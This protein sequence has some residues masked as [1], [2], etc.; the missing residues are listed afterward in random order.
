MQHM[1]IYVAY[2]V[3]LC[4]GVSYRPVQYSFDF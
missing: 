1:E 2:V 4:V 3:R